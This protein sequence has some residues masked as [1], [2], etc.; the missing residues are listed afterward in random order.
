MCY[1]QGIAGSLAAGLGLVGTDDW[2]GM[3]GVL[4]EERGAV[5]ST[6]EGVAASVAAPAVAEPD[7]SWLDEIHCL[8]ARND[9]DDAWRSLPCLYS[10]HLFWHAEGLRSSHLYEHRSAC[11]AVLGAAC[12]LR[13]WQAPA[14]GWQAAR[15]GLCG[16]GQARSSARSGAPSQ[17]VS[18]LL[19]PPVSWTSKP[20]RRRRAATRCTG[21]AG[22]QT[23]CGLG[24]WG[25]SSQVAHAV[26]SHPAGPYQRQE[27]VLGQEHHNP[28]TKV[29]PFDG[30]WNIYS[31]THKVTAAGRPV[32]PTHWQIAVASSTDQVHEND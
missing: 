8:E 5:L 22:G 1:S 6:A 9:G 31:I 28:E 11:C 21:K 4:K 32:T 14:R 26:A 20:S 25:G 30:S 12:A 13:C 27:L 3:I 18:H 23:R 17:P 7:T 2:S 10:D 29:S 19:H 24:N 15:Q 16:S